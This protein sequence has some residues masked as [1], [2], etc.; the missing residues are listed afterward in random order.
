MKSISRERAR[1]VSLQFAMAAA[2]SNFVTE[3]RPWWSPW[4]F[5]WSHHKSRWPLSC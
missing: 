5:A 4:I 2:K 3:H 1:R